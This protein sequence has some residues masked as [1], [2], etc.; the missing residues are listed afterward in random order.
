MPTDA[1]DFAVARAI[2]TGAMTDAPDLEDPASWTEAQRLR[3]YRERRGSDWLGVWSWWCQERWGWVGQA[4][5]VVADEVYC[6]H[7]ERRFRSQAEAGGDAL[8]RLEPVVPVDLL[9]WLPG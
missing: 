2:Q 9:D 1:L 7:S 3:W 5:L 8:R 6:V 4:V